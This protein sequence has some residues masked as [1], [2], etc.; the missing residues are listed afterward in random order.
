MPIGI[1]VLAEEH[2]SIVRTPSAIWSARCSE[3]RIGINLTGCSQQFACSV[4]QVVKFPD[5]AN[6]PFVFGKFRRVR[7]YQ[8]D[9][10][11]STIRFSR[12]VLPLKPQNEMDFADRLSS[13]HIGDPRWDTG[14]YPVRDRRSKTL[15]LEIARHGSQPGNEKVTRCS[16]RRRR[17]FLADR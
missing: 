4:R 13:R 9:R 7:R 16:Q 14:C 6:G 17:P 1:G 11:G 2:S 8:S 10:P 3:F 5:T 15:K 12:A